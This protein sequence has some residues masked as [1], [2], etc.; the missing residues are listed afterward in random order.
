[1][2]GTGTSIKFV[3]RLN[4]AAAT[5]VFIS[6]NYAN[7]YIHRWSNKI[8]VFCT[9]E[10]RVLKGI[11]VCQYQSPAYFL[12]GAPLVYLR[13]H[14]LCAYCERRYNQHSDSPYSVYETK[15]GRTLEDLVHES[16]RYF[17]DEI[18]F[19]KKRRNAS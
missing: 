14:G 15:Q 12:K 2:N 8:R 1:M 17:L 6:Y 13:F 3:A 4:K 19:S 5:V 16:I 7:S 11:N 18:C 10:Q 9:T